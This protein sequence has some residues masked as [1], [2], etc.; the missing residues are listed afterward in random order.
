MAQKLVYSQMAALT[1]AAVRKIL[2]ELDM[3]VEQKTRYIQCR[4]ATVKSK[5]I[6][7][8]NALNRAYCTEG[9]RCPF[10]KAEEF[11][12]FRRVNIGN[13]R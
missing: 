6:T 8:C 9:Y 12:K 10:Y 7:E 13:L 3:E 4:F 11:N 5:E 1:Q 2:K